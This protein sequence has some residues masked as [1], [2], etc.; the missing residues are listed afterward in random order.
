MPMLTRCEVTLSAGLRSLDG[1]SGRLR[2]TLVLISGASLIGGGATTEAWD[3]ASVAAIFGASPET[4]WVVLA[5]EPC[6]PC[7][8]SSEEI[9]GVVS[10]DETMRAVDSKWW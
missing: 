8:V 1:V 10:C 4:D 3:A 2:S 7:T 6:S 9:A 5:V